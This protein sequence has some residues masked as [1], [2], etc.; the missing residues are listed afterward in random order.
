MAL[1]DEQLLTVEEFKEAGHEV[2]Y[3]DQLMVQEFSLSMVATAVIMG[4]ILSPRA[5]AEV[6]LIVQTFGL[7]FLSLLTLHLRNLNQDRRA[8]V[9]R[10]EAL[11][12]ALDF[13]PIHQGIIQNRG[14]PPLAAPHM[15]VLFAGLATLGWLFW[16]VV[17]S[18][19]YFRGA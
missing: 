7:L 13:Q 6:N 2:R 17:G 10:K 14:W 19:A 9:Y 5:Q 1:S 16:L 15:M 18:L 11:R 8:A 12:L 4:V 3:R